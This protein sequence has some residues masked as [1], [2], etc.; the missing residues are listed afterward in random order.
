MRM[1]D[2]IV[3]GLL[4]DPEKVGFDGHIKRFQVAFE[5]EV[6]LDTRLLGCLHTKIT[7]GIDNAKRFQNGGHQVGRDPADLLY[8]FIE[9]GPDLVYMILDLPLV[10]I[11]QGSL[12]YYHLVCYP[13]CLLRINLQISL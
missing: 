9:I 10:D 2:N 13:F 11:Q 12:Y 8:G 5:I 7:Y 1:P 6:D 3:Y 4:R